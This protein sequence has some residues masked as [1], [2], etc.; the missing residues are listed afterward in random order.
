RNRELKQDYS[1]WHLMP[2]TVREKE[3]KLGIDAH[4]KHHTFGVILKL[5]LFAVLEDASVLRMKINELKSERGR[6]EATDALVDNIKYS[7]L[8]L[9]SSDANGFEV[10]FGSG[11]NR[12]TAKVASTPF[13]IDI[14]NGETLVMSGNQHGLFNFEHFRH[15]HEHTESPPKDFD[16]EDWNPELDDEP[17]YLWEE[18]FKTF[19]D[20]KPYGP[21]SVGMD[22]SFIGFDHV[23]GIPEHADSFALK[24]TKEGDPYRL[25]NLDVFEYELN[26]PMALYGSVP[27]MVAH[28]AER[29]VGL[30]WL[31]PSETWVDIQPSSVAG[32]SGILANLVSG[33]TKSRLTHWISET[34]VIDAWFML[35]PKPADVMAQNAKITGT[36]AM[37]PYYSI[38]HH[39]CRWNYFTEKEV[40]EVNSGFDEHDIPLDAIWLDIEYTKGRSKKYFTWDP[41]SFSDPKTLTSNLTSKG[42]RLITIIDPH[43]KKDSDYAIYNE[44]VQN[45]YLVK[46]KEGNDY[47]GWCW[48]GASMY[49]DYVNPATREWWASKFNPEFFPGF[50]GG[51]VDIWNDMNEPSVFNGPETTAPKDLR[52]HEGWEHRDVHNMYG[53]LMVKA[54]HSGLVAHRHNLRPFI[55]TRSFFVGSQRYCAAWTGDNM[56]KWDHLRI[57][58][59]MLLSMSIVGMSFAGADVPGFFFNPESEELVVRWYQAGTF[60]PFFRAHAHLDTNR[61]EPWTFSE[62]TKQLIRSSIRTRY[63]YLPYMYTLVYENHITG[64]PVMQPLWFQFTSDVNT[65]AIDD[66]YMLGDS[67]LVFPVTGNGVSS[68]KVYFPGKD[69]DLWLH[70]ESNKIYNGGNHAIVMVS[71]STIP[72]FQKGGTILAKRERIRRSAALTLNDPFTFDI[73]LEPRRRSASGRLYL[74]DG[75]TF[76]YQNGQFLYSNM[77]FE[78]NILTYS[79]NGKFVTKSWLE[80]VVLYRC[81]NKPTAVEVKLG[82]STFSLDSKYDFHKQILVIR[83]PGVSLGDSWQIELKF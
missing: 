70:I 52:H 20:S 73:F 53:Y 36:V 55:L 74:D 49:A 81:P 32:A 69:S 68:I 57:V 34:G 78:K 19:T 29:T 41:I 12:H 4:L 14:Y 58:V 83:K 31:N 10:A 42:R 67:L 17:D 5:E 72:F 43:L 37:P 54:T 33:D 1:Q 80:K 6:Y 65:F 23:Y 21:M 7:K 40:S 75:Y 24:N 18:T 61:R 48:P 8:D 22:I 79:A 27:F 51:L 25:Y 47:E 77:T 9:L 82:D 28:S 71:L 76:D 46:T 64:M 66:S 56:A 44:A 3:D 50:E 62:Q 11:N 16:P 30:L 15:K 26:S 59:P 63:A 39:Q 13:R 38:G 2:E 45:N 35:G 60:Q